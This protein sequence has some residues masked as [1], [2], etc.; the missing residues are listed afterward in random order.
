MKNFSLAQAAQIIGV[1]TATIRNWVKSGD[2]SP[3][4]SRPIYFTEK[5]IFNLK[6]KIASSTS[7]RLKTRANKAASTNNFFPSEYAT[8]ASLLKQIEGISDWVQQEKLNVDMVLFFS[9]LYLLAQ[10]KEV[11]IQSNRDGL[12]EFSECS[13]WRRDSIKNVMHEWWGTFNTRIINN[14]YSHLEN[15]ICPQDE[16]DYLG[17]L[18]QSLANEGSKSEQGAYLTPTNLVIDSLEHIKANLSAPIQLFLDPCCGTGKYLLHAAQR[19]SLEPDN[20]IGLEA[21]RISVYLAKINLLLAFQ[22]REFTPKIHQMD[23]ISDLATGDFFCETNDLIDSIDAIATN[24]PWGAYKNNITKGRLSTSIKTGETFSLFLEKSIRLLR[25][26]GL[27]SFIL[28]ESILTVK[29]HSDIRSLLLKETTINKISLLGRQFTGV[30]TPVIRLDLKKIRSSDQWM[31]TVDQ[32]GITHR[33]PQARFINNENFS[34]DIHIKSN[35]EKLI[36]RIYSVKHDTLAGNAEWALGIVTGNNQKY[37][38][39]APVPGSEPIVRGTDI[40]PYYL[41]GPQSFICYSPEKYQQVAN[42]K[43]YRAPEKLFYKFISKNLVFAYD[44]KQLLS[45]NSANILIP[46]IP[47][48][49]IKVVLAYLNSSVFQFIFTKK[50]STHKVLRGDL[51]KLPFPSISRATHDA[52]A[53][54]V[55]NVIGNR[56]TPLELEKIIYNSFSLNQ[57]DNAY[58]SHA[59]RD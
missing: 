23:T 53:H 16:E 46:S 25:S 45:L 26:G 55:D 2:I 42:E 6:D 39:D 57:A 27:L 48:M 9:A 41:L 11:T 7:G 12:F 19:L 22:D 17:L 35:E 43:F 37:I 49:S 15:L 28:P 51:E 58:I 50:F 14:S 4:S 3:A 32:S 33:V 29:T 44:D 30:Y 20:I 13:Y 52:I 10:K 8:N 5:S 54:L 38:F 34:F 1:S 56:A 18:Y 47:G 36:E 40:H 24:P 21:D 31:I 59:L